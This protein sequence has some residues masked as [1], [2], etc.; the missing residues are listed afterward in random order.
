VTMRRCQSLLLL[1]AVL[2]ACESHIHATGVVRDARGAGVPGATVSVWRANQPGAARGQTD[3]GGH[4]AVDH[5][6][7]R[8]GRVV[9]QACYPGYA[10]VQKA[11]ANE[12]DIPDTIVLVLRSPAP[13]AVAAGC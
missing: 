13:A 4:F 12:R 1:A 10:I 6:G 8:R 5:T 3:S 7:G 11:W 2:A 9:V